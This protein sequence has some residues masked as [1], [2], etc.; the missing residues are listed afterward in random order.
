MF[1]S[2]VGIVSFF[3]LLAPLLASPL[4][5]RAESCDCECTTTTAGS[6]K[7]LF[8]RHLLDTSPEYGNFQQSP[9]QGP[10]KVGI[11]GA[12]AAGLYAGMLL[13][14]LG[15]DYEILEGSDRIGGR[16]YTHR[17][18]EAAWNAS[19]PGEPDYYNYYVWHSLRIYVRS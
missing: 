13:Q 17:F 11:V 15:I 6:A 12:G 14:S 7:D 2:A 4:S 5:R 10:L 3:S 19:K 16:M 1:V 8:L 18:D 9:T